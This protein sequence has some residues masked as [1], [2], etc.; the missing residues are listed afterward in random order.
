MNA[1]QVQPVL[2]PTSNYQRP[3][4]V[5]NV[6]Q[7][8]SN[9]ISKS[10]ASS[11]GSSKPRLFDNVE[12]YFLSEHNFLVNCIDMIERKF[13][14]EGWIHLQQKHKFQLSI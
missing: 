14:L 13:R 8:S 4:K 3:K 11:S 2:P 6:Q 10:S 5:S 12:S 7:G 9:S 1:L